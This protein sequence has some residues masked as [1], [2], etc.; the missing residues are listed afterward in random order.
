MV[1][2]PSILAGVSRCCLAA[3]L[4][5]PAPISQ[6]HGYLTGQ[7]GARVLQPALH[8]EAILQWPLIQREG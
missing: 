4:A 7:A 3:T 5:L 8:P 1:P 2:W 6:K